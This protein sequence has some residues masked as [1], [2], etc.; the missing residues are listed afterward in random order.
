MIASLDHNGLNTGI[1]FLRVHSWAVDMLL[2]ALA[3]PLSWPEINL[4]VSADQ[5]AMARI[6]QKTTG[7]PN[8]QG[9]KDGLVYLPRI[10][11]NAYQ[12]LD[13]YEGT[14]G[15]MLVHFPG[16]GD[17]RWEQMTRWLDIIE[18]APDKWEVPLEQTDYLNK[19]T[20]FWTQFR[21]ANNVVNRMQEHLQSSAAAASHGTVPATARGAAASRLKDAL[22]EHADDL[23]MV[24][25]R[26]H[27]LYSAA[28][29][30]GDEVFDSVSV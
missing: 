11:I 20:T 7:G 21:A 3:Y 4:G 29:E 17:A 14:E 27:E 28:D 25:Q 2:E 24:R 8:R 9:Y 23:D 30:E 13:A 6:L 12:S 19:T 22:E 10:W 26:L 18:M 5:E 1:F 15:D 16:L